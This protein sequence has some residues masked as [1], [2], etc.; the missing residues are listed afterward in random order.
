VSRRLKNV[1]RISNA[2][3]TV[4]SGLHPLGCGGYRTHPQSL[5]GR[6]AVRPAG[7]KQAAGWLA[8]P[9]MPGVG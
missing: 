8:L 3:A 2:I 4:P 9:D 1:V 7:S 6:L 5:A